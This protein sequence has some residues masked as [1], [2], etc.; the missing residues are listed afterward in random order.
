[1]MVGR[2]ARS[3]ELGQQTRAKQQIGEGLPASERSSP[4]T[5]TSDN[6]RNWQNI[7]IEVCPITP[8]NKNTNLL[9]LIDIC[10]KRK[11]IEKDNRTLIICL[12]NTFEP[13]LVPLLLSETVGVQTF[14]KIVECGLFTTW[15]KVLYKLNLKP[16]SLACPKLWLNHLIDQR[17][18]V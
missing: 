16:W 2:D 18:R 15:H 4:S 12:K 1:M 9:S 7:R 10:K 8:Q 5:T 11:L 3:A 6:K 13:H 17:G 14:V